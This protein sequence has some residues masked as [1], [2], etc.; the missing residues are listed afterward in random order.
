MQMRKK[1]SLS[2]MHVLVYLFAYFKRKVNAQCYYNEYISLSLSLASVERIIAGHALISFLSRDKCIKQ[3]GSIAFA[4]YNVARA[5]RRAFERRWRS[6]LRLSTESTRRN[7]RSRGFSHRNRANWVT[8]PTHGWDKNQTLFSCPI[9]GGPR[10]SVAHEFY[11]RYRA[12]SHVLLRILLSRFFDG[13]N[14]TVRA[15]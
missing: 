11:M 1:I 9:S 12:L 13:H 4:I 3:S 7:V 15:Q 2:Y 6:V 5:L 10:A 14:N 8:V